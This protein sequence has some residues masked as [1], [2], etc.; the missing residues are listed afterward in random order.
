MRLTSVLIFA[1]VVIP[2]MLAAPTKCKIWLHYLASKVGLM[3]SKSVL[4]LATLVPVD[5][6]RL[7]QPLNVLKPPLR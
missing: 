4:M 2:E 6:S 5:V 7:Y 3:F 1:T